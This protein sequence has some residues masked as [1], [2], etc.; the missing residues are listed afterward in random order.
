M[1]FNVE[2]HCGNF[3]SSEIVRLTGSKAVRETYIKEKNLERKLGRSLKLDF[4][5][6][7]TAWG[8]LIEYWVL[9]KKIGTE[10]AL[11]SQET[12]RHPTVNFWVGSPDALKYTPP[13]KSVCDVKG[14]GLKNFCEM[15]DAFEKGGITEVRSE[16]DSGEKFYKQLLSNGCIVGVDYAELILACPYKSELDEIRNLAIN[17]DG[18]DPGRFKQFA[19]KED[20][21]MPHLPDS[22]H[23]KNLNFFS[24]PLPADDRIA[25]HRKVVEA[26]KELVPFKTLITA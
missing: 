13:L 19:F 6:K 18:P 16:C 15:V 20:D 26:G 11:T 14:L 23:Y 4:Y 25:L 24:F 8:H 17:Y 9:H 21:E 5:S 3:S 2:M 22:G 12:L 1:G 10:Y 7:D